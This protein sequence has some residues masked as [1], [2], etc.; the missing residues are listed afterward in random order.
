MYYSSPF[1]PR[2]VL[3]FPCFQISSQNM[4]PIATNK[5][6]LLIVSTDK[7]G[8]KAN[9]SCIYI[10]T[11]SE[12]SVLQN[13]IQARKTHSNFSKDS[14]LE[15]KQIN[16][17]ESS[18]IFNICGAELPF[19]RTVH[20]FNR[21]PEKRPIDRF[22]TPWQDFLYF[23]NP[24][25]FHHIISTCTTERNFQG[26]QTK[27][28]Y[29]YR[30]FF[31]RAFFPSRF[32]SLCSMERLMG[33]IM[34]TRRNWYEEGVSVIPIFEIENSEV[35]KLLRNGGRVNVEAHRWIR[36]VRT[37]VTKV[38]NILMDLQPVPAVYSLERGASGRTFPIVIGSG[39]ILE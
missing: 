14:K 19:S 26:E 22:T 7:I 17:S 39:S 27:R 31:L 34:R 13:S 33:I 11:C 23:S 9:V 36:S 24:H 35:K 32:H 2:P 6:L 12:S 37:A 29:R 4:K 5:F 1:D 18:T 21:C 3:R 10:Y 30:F 28:T 15:G 25:S 20:M 8:I 38:K 16:S